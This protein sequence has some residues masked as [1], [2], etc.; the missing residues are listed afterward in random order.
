MSPNRAAGFA[1]TMRSAIT[2]AG[3]RERYGSVRPSPFPFWASVSTKDERTGKREAGSPP[4]AL[5]FTE[6]MIYYQ[7][8][9]ACV[10]VASRRDQ[11]SLRRYMV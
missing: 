4:F 2:T 10:I 6:I 1:P 9:L 3:E 5:P 7:S 11:S 8:G